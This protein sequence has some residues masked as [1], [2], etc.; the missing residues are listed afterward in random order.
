MMTRR[1]RG[2]VL[3]LLEGDLPSVVAV[4]DADA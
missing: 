2:E 1:L 4:F 3:E